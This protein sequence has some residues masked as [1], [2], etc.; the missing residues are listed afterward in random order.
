MQ[1]AIVHICLFL[2][3]QASM[4]TQVSPFPPK[5]DQFQISPAASPKILHHTVWRTWLF[6]AYSNERWSYYQ[7]SPLLTYTFLFETVRRMS[8][9]SWGFAVRCT[10]YI[11]GETD[12]RY[13]EKAN[14]ASHQPDQQF[15]CKHLSSYQLWVGAGVYETKSAVGD[16]ELSNLTERKLKDLAGGHDFLRRLWPKPRPFLFCPR[17]FFL[18]WSPQGA[19]H[20]RWGLFLLRWVHVDL[21][22][23]RFAY[24]SKDHSACLH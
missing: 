23:S 12:P 15:F 10:A 13:S 3:D 8:F 4:G 17:G 19:L 18:V 7:F 22:N 5:S 11:H 6:I 20:M 1:Y 24:D 2:S 16:F 21:S 14:P 9:L